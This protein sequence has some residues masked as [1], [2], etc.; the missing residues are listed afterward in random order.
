MRY[1][2]PEKS[3][4]GGMHGILCCEADLL[5]LK[6][7]C[8]MLYGIQS[9]TVCRV[10]GYTSSLDLLSSHLDGPAVKSGMRFKIIVTCSLSRAL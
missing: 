6:F 2:S 5:V 1:L 8:A 3:P 7:M 9:D 10:H 4:T